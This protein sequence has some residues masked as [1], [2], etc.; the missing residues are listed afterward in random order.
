MRVERINYVSERNDVGVTPPALYLD[1][2]LA[3]YDKKTKIRGPRTKLIRA[4]RDDGAAV[5]VIN[6][7]L[8]EEAD[9][10]LIL[11]V[12]SNRKLLSASN[13]DLHHDH[14]GRELSGR[15]RRLDE[16]RGENLRV[17]HHPLRGSYGTTAHGESKIRSR[18]R[19]GK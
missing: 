13:H 1:L 9:S 7:D 14:H 19:L 15:A 18:G 3:S 17:Y 16:Y 8:L 2:A 11:W 5:S 4:H 12:R 10:L 6:P